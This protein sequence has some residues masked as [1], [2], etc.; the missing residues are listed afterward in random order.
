MRSAY[1]DFLIRDWVESDRTSAANVIRAVLEEY[2]L[3]WEGGASCC[4]GAD[5]DA[6]EVEKYYLATGGEFWVVER[7]GEIVGTGGYHPI[8]RGQNAVEIRKMYLLPAARGYGLGR[9]LLSQLEQAIAKKG[10]A[11]AWVET[12]TV[13]REAVKLYERNG[14]EPMAGVETERCDKVYCKTLVSTGA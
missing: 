1:K 14:Y 13:L 8:E 5:Q 7:D 6:V 11:Q 3:G 12:A 10:F 9:H 2:G 4:G